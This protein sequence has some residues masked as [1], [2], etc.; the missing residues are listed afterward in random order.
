MSFWVFLYELIRV[1]FWRF[2]VWANAALLF[3]VLAG[4]SSSIHYGRVWWF[5]EL[6]FVLTTNLLITIGITRFAW[7]H[8]RI[9]IGSHLLNDE[10]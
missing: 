6:G 4:L 8:W 9:I 10:E 3:G 7:E 2:Y 5:G 1:R